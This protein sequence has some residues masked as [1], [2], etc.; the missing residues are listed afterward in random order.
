[1]GC[2]QNDYLI[3]LFDITLDPRREAG[4]DLEDL[5]TDGEMKIH[6]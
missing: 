4:K 3:F 5:P 2:S 6:F 1:M